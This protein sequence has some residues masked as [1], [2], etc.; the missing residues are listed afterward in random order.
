[1]FC[2]VLR[3]HIYKYP[4]L[5]ALTWLSRHASSKHTKHLIMLHKSALD[6]YMQK[7]KTA[8]ICTCR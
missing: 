7:S 5:T 2:E 6:G 8:F 3:Y 4:K 1:V